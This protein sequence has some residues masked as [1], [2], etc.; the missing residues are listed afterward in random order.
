MCV[1]PHS[2]GT[3]ENYTCWGPC[4]EG[5]SCSLLTSGGLWV[6]KMQGSVRTLQGP[7]THWDRPSLGCTLAPRGSATQTFPQCH[8]R[9]F[10]AP[11][12]SL[13]F[14]SGPELLPF[15]HNSMGPSPLHTSWTPSKKN[16]GSGGCLSGAHRGRCPCLPHNAGALPSQ[17]LRA[18]RSAHSCP[19]PGLP[20]AGWHL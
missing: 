20:Q 1:R 13:Q 14:P 2:P 7:P 19:H 18:G 11:F 9:A 6:T 3:L 8:M 4:L 5:H 17:A 12:S 15:S 10:C 16:S